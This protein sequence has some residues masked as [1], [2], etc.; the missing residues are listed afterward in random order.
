M[1]GLVG[2]AAALVAAAVVLTGCT[3]ESTPRATADPVAEAVAAVKAQGGDADELAAFSD[4]TITYD[5]YEA[6]MTRAFDCERALGATVTVTGTKKEEGVT[7]IEATTTARSADAKAL[8]DCYTH[9]AQAVD[10]YWQVSSPDAVAF[11]ERRSAALLPALRDCL[12]RH[13]VDWAKDE[14]FHE[15]MAKGVTGRQ[16]DDAGSTDGAVTLDSGSSG[17]QLDCPAEI[18]YASW[19]G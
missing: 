2:T 16:G 14:S 9:H 17:A 3:G 5:E 12:T 6:A 15:L 18:G 4:R 1:H 11:Q 7:R 10:M 8:D 13:G 19:D